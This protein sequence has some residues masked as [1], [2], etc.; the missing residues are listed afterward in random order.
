MCMLG[1]E[2]AVSGRSETAGENSFSGTAAVNKT[3]GL[4]V[5]SL[6]FTVN[7]EYFLETAIKGNFS[8][9]SVV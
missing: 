9:V 3:L 6:C 2:W 4:L 5:A 8:V 7:R 1:I